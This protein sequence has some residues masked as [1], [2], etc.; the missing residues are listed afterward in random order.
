MV[1]VNGTIEILAVIFPLAHGGFLVSKT[2]GIPMLLLG[3]NK[4]GLYDDLPYFLMDLA[5]QGFIGRQIAKDISAQSNHFP[6]NPR[7]W[8]TNHIGHYLISNGD[9]LPGNLLFGIQTT[10]RRRLKPTPVTRDEYPKLAND[11]L[12]GELGGSSAGGEQPKFTAYCKECSSHVIVKFSPKGKDRSA[13]RWRDILIT[14]HHAT[15]ALSHQGL[16][17]A[18]T[19]LFEKEGRLFLE[20]K[21]FDRTG[22]YGR[23][24]MISLQ[25][26][27]AEYIGSGGNWPDIA[28]ELGKK[29]LIGHFHRKNIK[30]IWA[31]G[32]LIHNTDMHLG[33]LSLSMDGDVFRL[34]PVYDM[35]SMGFAPKSNG[36]VMPFNF[37]PP[38]LDTLN[39]NEAQHSISLKGA[40]DFWNRIANDERI[41]NDFKAFLKKGNPI[42][43]IPKTT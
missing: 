1:D 12:N 20:S 38:S 3:E 10:F 41:S 4:M 39:L 43:L 6:S 27:N 26:I 24:S 7:D 28:D 21:R 19:E 30:T 36:E 25:S 2:T 18:Q 5:P 33:N 8:N 15:N 22:E 23:T 42:T 32:K 16:P 9:D 35:C 34:C 37:T 11:A 17:A 29:K 40:H 14:E 31:F 13:Q